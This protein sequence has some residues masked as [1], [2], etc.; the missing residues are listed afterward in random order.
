MGE[1]K[2]R[3][4]K[5]SLAHGGG[6]GKVISLQMILISS[7]KYNNQEIVDAKIAAGDF[8]VTLSASFELDGVEYAIVLDGHHRMEAARQMGVEPVYHTDT[9]SE[10]SVLIQDGEIEAA[11][12]AAWLD[13]DWYD[14]ESLLPVF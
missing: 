9:K 13:S 7:Q 5:K 4:S 14:I 2:F 8:T 6:S 1:K 11:L 12:E 3:R 10:I